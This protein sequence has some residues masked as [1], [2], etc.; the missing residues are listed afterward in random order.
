MTKYK[1]PSTEERAVIMIEHRK[2]SGMK[3]IARLFGRSASKV[4]RELARNDGTATSHY[5]AARLPST[6][7][8]RRQGCERRRKLLVC[9]GLVLEAL[10][11]AHWPEEIELRPLAGHWEGDLIKGVRNRSAVGTLGERKAR[12][13]VLCRMG[14]R[15][16]Q[17]ALEGFTRL[18][19]KL[20]AL[21]RESLTYDRG[22]AMTCHVELSRRLNLDIWFAEPHAP[23]S[24][25]AMRTPTVC[26]ASF[27]PKG[28]TFRQSHRSSSTTSPNYSTAGL[29][30]RL[31]GIRP[32]K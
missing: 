4:S 8:V 16:A 1:H 6:Y 23:D 28:W 27:S 15:A 31:A 10:H 7:R 13:T 22:T 3:T 9:G 21:L 2:G 17:G 20:P 18:M 30:R 25:A 11:I 5:D 19:K 12:F 32:R 26:P 24:A 29:V 14:G